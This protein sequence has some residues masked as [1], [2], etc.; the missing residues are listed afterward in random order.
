MKRLI[1]LLVMTC[2]VMPLLRA[3]NG[4]NQY[5]SPDEFRT[6]QKAFIIE[7]A[8]LTNEEAAIF[9]PLYFELQDRKK[10]LND[11]AWA[12]LRKGKDEETTEARYREI[13][14]GVYDARIASD[15]LDK[16]YFDK[17]K[18]ILSYKKIYLVQR[19]E[20]RFHRELLRG[21]HKKGERPQ[22]RMQGGSK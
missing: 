1:V 6:K 7:K 4:I 15:R 3:G 13:L 8:G 17:F 20:M 12:L 16:T 11:E 2:G 21:M 5:L 19:A 14:E 18:K 9:F 22:R 10:Q